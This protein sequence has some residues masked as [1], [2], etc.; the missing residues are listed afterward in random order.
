MANND[1]D[2]GLEYAPDVVGKHLFRVREQYVVDHVAPM[3]KAG[4]VGAVKLD[5]VLRGLALL[6]QHAG[7]REPGVVLPHRGRVTYE[8]LHDLC[9][10][11][12]RYSTARPE[13]EIDDPE[14]LERKRTWVREQLQ[15]LERR[16]LV[17]RDLVPGR[18][19]NIYVLSDRGDGTPLDDAGSARSRAGNSYVTILGTVIGSEHFR[20]WGAPELVG[21]ICAMV[22]DRY[23][24]FATKGDRVP[25][26]GGA[27]WFRQA[28]WF[29]NRNGYWPAGHVALPFSTTTI[30]RGLAS[31]SGGPLISARWAKRH[32]DT[33]HRLTNR[34]KIY[35]N[36]FDTLGAAAEVIDLARLA[37]SA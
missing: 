12:R 14:V 3:I 18:R 1:D 10:D 26:V 17:R 29:N 4:Q 23:A 9:R 22:A 31:L 19:P 13:D 28:P 11:P 32:P 8:V 24:R 15:I 2:K 16:K 27:T 7:E 25:P 37:R 30:E 5:L 6:P 21:Y 33:G 36:H 20:G 34:R 35:T